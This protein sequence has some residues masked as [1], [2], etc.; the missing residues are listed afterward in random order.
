MGNWKMNGTKASVHALLQH[1]KRI[2]P[3]DNSEVVI[4]PSY[5]HLEKAS[6]E[7]RDSALKLGAQNM[8]QFADGAYTGEVSAAMLKDIG[9]EFVLLGH[10]ERRHVMHE[11]DQ[12]IAEKCLRSAEVG[13]RPVLC[14]GETMEQR[15][16][17]LTEKI[18]L[19]QLQSVLNLRDF[20]AFLPQLILAYEPVW[21]IGTGL[22]A[23]PQQAQEV[24]LLL[25]QALQE[26]DEKLVNIPIIYGG[27]VK[28]NN[29]QYLF[30]EP[31]IDG[32][33]IGGASLNG[34]EFSDISHLIKRV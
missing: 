5:I 9:C 1:I 16:K 21:A 2:K 25:R 24:H 18:V 6:W 4:F 17:K 11:S 29:A 10:S 27:S 23:T 3:E 26:H 34:Q 31:D 28:A 13:L 14:V 15:K 22:T 19:A 12:T 8:S 32:A 7:L 30:M 33:L 20:Q